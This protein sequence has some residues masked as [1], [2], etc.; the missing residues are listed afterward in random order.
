MTLLIAVLTAL[1]AAAA[2]SL[3]G[4][5]VAIDQYSWL[6]C[7]AG[8]YTSAW[9]DEV[10]LER[11]MTDTM[12]TITGGLQPCRPPENSREVFAVAAYYTVADARGI[13]VT[14]ISQPLPGMNVTQGIPELTTEAMCVIARS[15]VRLACFAISWEI[16]SGVPVARYDG[17]LPLNDP[18]VIENAFTDLKIKGGSGPG[19]PL[20]P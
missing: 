12:V 18:R 7:P 15:D 2:P 14:F 4:P 9:I 8:T 11:V 5:P 1:A 3:A 13:P 16:V 6:S 19:C 20:C 10:R 17:A